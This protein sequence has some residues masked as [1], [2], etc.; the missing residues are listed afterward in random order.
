[1]VVLTQRNKLTNYANPFNGTL[2]N[3]KIEGH[4][5]TLRYII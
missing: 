2:C 1:M 5:H 3:K 4:I